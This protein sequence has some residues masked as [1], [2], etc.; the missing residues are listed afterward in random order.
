MFSEGPG[1]SLVTGETSEP[2]DAS[3]T[4]SPRFRIPGGGRPRTGWRR[5]VYAAEILALA[6]LVSIVGWQAPRSSD[7]EGDSVIATTPSIDISDVLTSASLSTPTTPSLDFDSPVSAVPNDSPSTFGTNDSSTTLAV[8]PAGGDQVTA[9]SSEPVAVNGQVRRVVAYDG[10][11][12]KGWTDLGYSPSRVLNRGAAKIDMGYQ[13][14]WI[15]AR[16]GEPLNATIVE[17]RY[18]TPKPL[19]AFLQVTL[20][21]STVEQTSEIAVANLK[22]DAKGWY[23]ASIPVSKLNP[24]GIPFDRIRIRPTRSLPSP[25]LVEID[26]LVFLEEKGA[27]R[28]TTLASASSVPTKTSG[29]PGRMSIDCSDVRNKISP[30]IYGIAHSGVSNQTESPWTIGATINRWGGNPT[31]RYNWQI[32]NAWNTANDYYF[33][34]VAINDASNASEFF[35]ANND[36]YGLRSAMTLP[37]LG[38]VAKDTTSY[39][40]PVTKFG[41][42]Q[43]T[44]PYNADI[45]NGVTP[46]GKKIEP[47]TPKATSTSSTP[48]SVGE[49]VKSMKGRVTMYFLDNEPELWDST[50]R[51][52]HPEPLTYDELLDKTIRYASAVRKAD[53][54]A[55]IAGPSS[56]GWPAYFYSAADA[57]AG[58]DRAPDRRAHGNLALIPWY[59]QQI[60]ATESQTSQH[61][62][63]VLD[64]H[65]YPAGERVYEGGQGATDAAT[66][67]LRIR[68]VRGLWDRDYKDESWVGEPIYLIPRLR[69]WIQQYAPGL[70]ISV[71]E[72]NF[73]GESHMS[74]GLATA[75]A[76]GRFGLEDVYSAYYWTN[77]PVNSPSYWAFRAFRNFDGKG[78][79][80]LGQSIGTTMS[81]GL[82]LFASTN[83]ARTE[84]TAIVLNTDPDSAKS[85]TIELKACGTA[86]RFETFLYS[87]APSG[88]AAQGSKNTVNNSLNLT[89]P[90]YAMAVVRI[91]IG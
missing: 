61:L 90:A 25:L 64:V 69:E 81:A 45:G 67:A 77:P 56:W 85:P 51:D 58:F 91:P 50:Q 35:L 32:P 83:D 8:A 63:D 33:R 31:S 23:S 47:G 41:P 1:S 80:F 46:D 86:S 74:G 3:R 44:D 79:Q 78:G 38:W 60:R 34:N 43:A 53:P 7:R 27:T 2:A 22:P 87:G 71:G 21:S 62:L 48:D 26:K 84:V 10:K 24:K 17:F 28:T 19:G 11:L 20:A 55:L 57:K 36:L 49:W 18:R 15:V 42:Q 54:T 70:G 66:A 37:M 40:F 30:L 89:L 14:G 59:L 72:W 65:F 39:S 6:G 29:L 68:Q 13:M 4:K 75:E 88:F 73:G 12:A 52:V 76:L 9:V 5:G 82:S 16:R